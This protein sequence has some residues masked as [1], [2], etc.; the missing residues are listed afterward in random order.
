[1]Y[2]NIRKKSFIGLFVFM[3]VSIGMMVGAVIFGWSTISSLTTQ[4]DINLLGTNELKDNMNVKGEI[5]AVMDYFASDDMGR[6]YIIPVGTEQYMGMYV[7]NDMIDNVDEICNNTYDY[8]MDENGL[9][10][11]DKQIN[12][13][14]HIYKMTNTIE[15]Y[16]IDWFKETEYLGGNSDELINRYCVSYVYVAE[17]IYNFLNIYDYIAMAL[18]GVGFILFILS[19]VFLIGGKATWKIKKYIKKNGLTYDMV[20]QDYTR[21]TI[22]AKC[23]NAVVGR[24]FIVYGNCFS[25]NIIDINNV[26][27]AYK[28]THTTIHKTYGVKTGE[29]VEYSTI[30]KLRNGGEYRIKCDKEEKVHDMLELLGNYRYITIGWS[31]DLDNLYRYNLLEFVKHSDYSRQVNY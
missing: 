21:G 1:M 8:L 24:R 31:E 2:K 23:N 29:T 5:Y 27:W 16:F 18:M 30:I 9:V 17:P 14:G 28:Y 15:E 25:Y 7:Y 4:D 11:L 12:T 13:Y 26:V 20:E 3:L 6:Y 10:N 22:F 19:M